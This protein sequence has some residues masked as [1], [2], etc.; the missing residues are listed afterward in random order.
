M[1]LNAD[2]LSDLMNIWTA[3]FW[4]GQFCRKL[5][6][7]WRFFDDVGGWVVGMPFDTYDVLLGVGE[8]SD[9]FGNPD[10]LTDE[11]METPLAEEARPQPVKPQHTPP[12]CYR[13]NHCQ[14]I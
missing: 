4:S 5:L 9:T 10:I 8:H 12:R 11:A 6:D 7:V 3:V 14:I 2:V 1:R 13:S